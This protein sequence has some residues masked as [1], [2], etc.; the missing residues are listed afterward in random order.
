MVFFFSTKSNDIQAKESQ[1]KLPKRQ[2]RHSWKD[3]FSELKS[4]VYAYFLRI[5]LIIT[6]L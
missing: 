2:G 5:T 1:K 6:A 4:I 3:V